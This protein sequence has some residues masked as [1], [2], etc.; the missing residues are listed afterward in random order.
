MATKSYSNIDKPVQLVELVTDN[1]DGTGNTDS[2]LPAEVVGSVAHD[3]VD[4]GKPVKIGGKAANSPTAVA[5]LDR[6]DAWF[7][8]YGAQIVAGT[9]ITAARG[10][11]ASMASLSTPTSATARALPAAAHVSN[12]AT[13]DPIFKANATSRIASAAAS[14][15]A[16]SAK[17]SAGEVFRVMGNNVKASVVYLKIYNKATAPTVGTDTPVLTVPIPASGVFNI[18]VG[19]M[20]GFYLGTGI[21]YGFTTDAADAGTTALL[22]G[23]ILDFCLTYA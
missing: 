19:G 23:D 15:N 8:Y 22:A 16:T 21:A 2:S 4:S 10:M 20:L 6:V 12:G 18:D 3:A 1:G 7:T 14:V 11:S 9:S 13:L 17:A 5:D